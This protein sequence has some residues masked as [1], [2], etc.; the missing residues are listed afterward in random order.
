MAWNKTSSGIKRFFALLAA[1]A[2]LAPAAASA[3]TVQI[4][5]RDQ[6]GVTTF[7]AGTYHSQLE[8]PS[9]IGGIIVDG[10]T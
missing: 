3:H 8:G 6:G 4:C 9:P 1:A 2:V 10:F 5:W 7:Y